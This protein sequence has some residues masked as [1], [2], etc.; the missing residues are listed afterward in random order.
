MATVKGRLA[1]IQRLEDNDNPFRMKMKG[2]RKENEKLKFEN[3]FFQKINVDATN[4]IESS[5]ETA[6]KILE[7]QEKMQDNFYKN[8]EAAKQ[9]EEKLERIN[10]PQ[11]KELLEQQLT[12]VKTTYYK[13][14]IL[15]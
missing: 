15:W 4:K 2:V 12:I 10:D 1:E 11:F 9:I 6:E 3:A 5:L 13:I 7:F 14:L 8:E